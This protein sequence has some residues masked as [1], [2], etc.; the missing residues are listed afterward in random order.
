MSI[1]ERCAKFT[2]LMYAQDFIEDHPFHHCLRTIK[3]AT[4]EKKLNLV[5]WRAELA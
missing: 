5:V 4:I 3:E 1:T 2:Q